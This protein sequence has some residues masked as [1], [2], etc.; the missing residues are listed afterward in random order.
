MNNFIQQSNQIHSV[1]NQW[2]DKYY[3]NRWFNSTAIY[4]DMAIRL[5]NPMFENL[6]HQFSFEERDFTISEL[7][8]SEQFFNQFYQSIIN[9]K[10]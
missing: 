6:V 8:V 3:H 2:Y 7:K 5:G 10:F 9:F 1:L 4:E